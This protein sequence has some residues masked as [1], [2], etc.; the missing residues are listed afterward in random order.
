MAD[1]SLEFVEQALTH[2]NQNKSQLCQPETTCKLFLTAESS[3]VSLHLS[4]DHEAVEK[5]LT[6][7]SGKNK[8]LF[9]DTVYF[10]ITVH[11]SPLSTQLRY[12]F[13]A[14]DYLENKKFDSKIALFFISLEVTDLRVLPRVLTNP[15]QQDLFTV[16]LL[17]ACHHVLHHILYLHVH[18][19]G[20]HTFSIRHELYVTFFSYF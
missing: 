19:K 9:L 20:R 16:G 17:K 13:M 8:L 7:I 4:L 5:H 3:L 18:M 10:F 6:I 2:N 15:T 11:K 12:Q 1:L 14:K